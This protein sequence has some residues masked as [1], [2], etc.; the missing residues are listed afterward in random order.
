MAEDRLVFHARPAVYHLELPLDVPV[1]PEDTGAQ[2]HRSVRV[3]AL[4]MQ[5][6]SSIFGDR[7]QARAK[8]RGKKGITSFVPVVVIQRQKKNSTADEL[9]RYQV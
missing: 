3:Q 4:T 2:F 1:V 7:Y 5:F 9:R 6:W 8:T